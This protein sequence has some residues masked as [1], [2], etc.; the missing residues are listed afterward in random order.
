MMNR[1]YGIYL[2]MLGVFMGCS[3]GVPVG[4]STTIEVVGMAGN[5]ADEHGCRGSAGYVWSTLKGECI[6]IFEAGVRLNHVGDDAEQYTTSAF[7]VFSAKHD[8][9]VELFLDSEPAQTLILVRED[10]GKPW[11]KDGWVLNAWKGYTLTYQ[12]QVRYVG[13]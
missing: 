8:H 12:G 5:D 10:E 6:R 4:G 11:V 7:A 1:L 9:Q 3:E 13:Q 2:V